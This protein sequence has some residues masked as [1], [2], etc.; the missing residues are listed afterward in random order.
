MQRESS[1]SAGNYS[2]GGSTVE[3]FLEFQGGVETL[4]HEVY[5]L[6]GAQEEHLLEPWQQ[7]V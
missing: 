6:A 3:P 4:R 2:H 5:N 1:H 7:R